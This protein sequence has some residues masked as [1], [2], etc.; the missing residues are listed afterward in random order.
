M[1]REHA[2]DFAARYRLQ[3]HL[4]PGGIVGLRL[5]H[6]F[7]D[8]RSRVAEALQKHLVLRAG[9]RVFRVERDDGCLDIRP[10]VVSLQLWLEHENW[11]RLLACFDSDGDS[12]THPE[13]YLLS[14]FE[15]RFLADNGYPHPVPEEVSEQPSALCTDLH[16]HFAGCVRGEDLLRIGREYR[17]AYPGHLLARAGIATGSGLIPS[18]PSAPRRLTGSPRRWSFPTIAR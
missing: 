6:P 17:V 1:I 10:A 5:V 14:P 7:S 4:A 2:L 13:P 16:V 12:S 11:R 3:L 15:T 8:R 9:E 18:K